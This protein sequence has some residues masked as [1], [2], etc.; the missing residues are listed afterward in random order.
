METLKVTFLENPLTLY[1]ILGAVAVGLA[2]SWRTAGRSGRWLATGLLIVAVLAG[3]IYTLETL[4]VTDREQIH[5]ALKDIAESVPAGRREHAMTYLDEKYRGWGKFKPGAVRAVKAALAMYDVQSIKLLG[6]PA[7]EVDGELAQCKVSAIIH[8]KRD[9][10]P[11]RYVLAWNVKWIKR[12]EGWR[13][14]RAEPTA[15]VMP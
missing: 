11:S 1:I 2:V 15:D 8:Y 12:P 3:G 6:T 13:I 7:V 5:L 10:K 14:R 9:G 4:V